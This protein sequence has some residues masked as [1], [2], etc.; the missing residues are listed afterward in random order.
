MKDLTRLVVRNAI[1]RVGLRDPTAVD[2]PVPGSR[3][4]AGSSSLLVE[5]QPDLGHVLARISKAS[6]AEE[7][8]LR[9]TRE[10]A[11]PAR[12]LRSRLKSREHAAR[13]DH[14][15]AGRKRECP[16]S[17]VPTR[18]LDDI[19]DA[20][21]AVWPNLELTSVHGR[22]VERLISRGGG[23][24]R[25]RARAQPPSVGPLPSAGPPSQTGHVSRSGSAPRRRAE[26][27]CG[28]PSSEIDS[29][30]PDPL[31]RRRRHDA[32]RYRR[33]ARP[34]GR[35]HDDRH[36]HRTRL[37]NSRYPGSR[38]MRFPRACDYRA[39]HHLHRRHEHAAWG[40]AGADRR[41]T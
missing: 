35:Q 41:G 8:H 5:R 33:G 40:G 29:A 27:C 19:G 31:A 24:G 38:R 16:R 15:V 9:P 18:R 2:R 37:M 36:A 23:R 3:A 17:L 30:R 1:W 20:S 22:L 28:R 11:S 13:L 26:P 6:C 12:E 32:R 21:R 10:R 7:R 14:D 39:S 34:H 25:R 4:L